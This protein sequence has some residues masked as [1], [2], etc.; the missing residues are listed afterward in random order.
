MA[1]PSLD[2]S[3]GRSKDSWPFSARSSVRAPLRCFSR[4][5]RLFAAVHVVSCEARFVDHSTP[6]TNLRI[7]H[8]SD[9]NSYIVTLV[10]GAIE[11][12]LLTGSAAGCKHVFRPNS[13]FP[14]RVRCLVMYLNVIKPVCFVC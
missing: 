8:V 9:T 3:V 14:S 13:R 7:V 12:S 11:V 2:P 5:G 10:E 6:L 1:Q 4:E